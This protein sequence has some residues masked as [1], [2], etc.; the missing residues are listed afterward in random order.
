MTT[1]QQKKT[2]QCN[3]S[4]SSLDK[5]DTFGKSDPYLII[6]QLTEGEEDNDGLK[7]IGRTAIIKK[8]I[9]IFVE[10]FLKLNSENLTM[11]LQYL[12]RVNILANS[13]PLG[14]E[15]ISKYPKTRKK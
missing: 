14:V 1:P 13:D 2:L 12:A 6:S 5:K 9:L 8:V 3:F 15:E 7:E 4:G 10:N 11:A